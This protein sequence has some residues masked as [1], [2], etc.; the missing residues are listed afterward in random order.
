MVLDL[1][2]FWREL[3]GEFLSS[4]TPWVMR[5][6]ERGKPEGKLRFVGEIEFCERKLS[7]ECF[8]VLKRMKKLPNSPGGSNLK[9]EK[10]DFPPTMK[11]CKSPYTIKR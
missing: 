5:G 10:K 2:S 1:L 8:T 6:G 11:N 4:Q 7:L 3:F 9:G